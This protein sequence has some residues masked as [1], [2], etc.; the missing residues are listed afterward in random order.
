[1]ADDLLALKGTTGDR[2]STQV[3]LFLSSAWRQ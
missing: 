2:K 3:P 1:M